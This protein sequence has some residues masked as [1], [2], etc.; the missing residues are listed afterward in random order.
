MRDFHMLNEEYH[1]V[2]DRP[3][4][5]SAQMM[6]KDD[7][8]AMSF[9]WDMTSMA[10]LSRTIIQR[11]VAI[12]DYKVTLDDVLG[13]LSVVHWT[14]VMMLVEREKGMPSTGWTD[15]SFCCADAHASVAQKLGPQ[16]KVRNFERWY[17]RMLSDNVLEIVERPNKDRR[18]TYF[19][20]TEN[21]LRRLETLYSEI[22]YIGN[23]LTTQRLHAHFEMDYVRHKFAIEATLDDAPKFVQG[24][25]KF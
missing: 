19:L 4:F 2:G 15:Y 25:L 3:D 7:P 9:L 12:W 17:E 5:A 23:L 16:F 11:M 24:E 22:C 8:I 18:K 21:Y 1:R 6:L 13:P 14:G 20:P 10:I